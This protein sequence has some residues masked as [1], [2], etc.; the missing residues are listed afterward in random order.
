MGVDLKE[1]EFDE[2]KENEIDDL[3]ES[4]DLEVM[5][6]SR[7]HAV[8][9]CAQWPKQSFESS[10]LAVASDSMGLGLSLE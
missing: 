6:S 4:Q 5:R 10:E 2:L 9:A 8:S 1:N 7:K 3:E